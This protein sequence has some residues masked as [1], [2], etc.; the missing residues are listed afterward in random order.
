MSIYRKIQNQNQN[1]DTLRAGTYWSPEEDKRLLESVLA[2]LPLAQIALDHKRTCGGI[3]LRIRS[4]AYEEYVNTTV[5]SEE[6]IRHLAHKYKI[7]Y[8]DFSMYVKDKEKYRYLQE[9]KNIEKEKIKQE[10]KKQIE[11]VREQKKQ[12]ELEKREQKEQLELEKREQK[13]QLEL[14]KKIQKEQLELEKKIQKERLEHEQELIRKLKEEEKEIEYHYIYCLREREFLRSGENIYK[15]GKTTVHPFKRIKQYPIGSELVLILKVDN[16]HQAEIELL[17]FLDKIYNSA[18]VNG[19]KIGREYYECN[20]E[21][22]VK[23]I[24]ECLK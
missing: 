12:L 2:D 11:L 24:F 13:E 17:K 4:L 18:Y 10:K 7:N 22:I 23:S 19:Q 16:C 3:E 8:E 15:V 6:L 20:E 14:E 21:E 1:P 5:R 9:I